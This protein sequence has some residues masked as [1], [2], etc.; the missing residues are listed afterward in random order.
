MSK[1]KAA[2]NLT[3][4]TK[5]AFLV[6][7]KKT[8]KPLLFLRN[9]KSPFAKIVYMS[10]HLQ[11]S[12]EQLSHPLAKA[13]KTS[14]VMHRGDAFLPALFQS[15]NHSPQDGKWSSSPLYW[16][17][18]SFSIFR[19]RFLHL[20]MLKGRV[21]FNKSFRFWPCN[22]FRHEFISKK[23]HFTVQLWLLFKVLKL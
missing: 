17:H 22:K 2:R 21:I 14:C 13:A 10:G 23:G 5:C 8:G 3:L 16:E 19:R 1:T 18:K 15:L 11:E 20:Q 4:F 7:K 6:I 9:L 12:T